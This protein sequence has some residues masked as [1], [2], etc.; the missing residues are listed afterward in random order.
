MLPVEEY[1]A[2][3]SGIR[4]RAAAVV[5]EGE[6][7]LSR[8]VR[9][10]E[11]EW[12]DMS[13][14]PKG[15]TAFGKVVVLPR[16]A[17]I[18]GRRDVFMHV[19]LTACTPAT[20]MVV[21]LGSGWGHN[22]LNLHLWGGPKVPYF[23]LEPSVP[24]REC[25][26]LLAA[27]EPRL[28]LTVLP[29]DLGRPRYELPTGSEHV[30]VFT[31]HS[32]EQVSELPHETLIGLFALGRSITVVHFEPIGWQLGENEVTAASREHALE[33]GYNR[34]LWPVLT[35]LADVG[36]ISIETAIPDLI[37]HKKRN[38]S[39]LVVWRRQALPMLG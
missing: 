6:R 38:A 34:N 23:A 27:L 8:V 5:A 24:G 15:G 10:L 30:L 25:V 37:G 21:E 32:I 2:I 9:R 7:D 26:E 22:L 12:R 17:L 14:E 20:S 19:L 1:D 4:D 36:E 31:A 11:R 18:G 33:K 13:M 16:A 28:E 39:S 29:F 3:W 35:E